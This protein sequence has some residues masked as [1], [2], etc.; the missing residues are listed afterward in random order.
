MRLRLP[1]GRTAFVVAALLFAL[2]A[3]LP[4]RLA[5][6]WFGFG[7]RGLTAR[8]V[9]GSVW[10]GALQQAQMGPVALGDVRARLNL[11]PLLLGRARLSLR[12]ADETAPI[13]GAVTVSRSGIAVD[14]VSGRLRIGGGM[15]LAT[16]DLQDL[17]AGFA[18]G[19]CVRA[20]GRVRATAAGPLTGNALAGNVRCDGAA[21]LFPLAGPSGAERLELRLFGDGRW[22]I[23]L[24]V[25]TAD[26]AVA[27]RLAAA[28]LRRSGSGY[29][30]RI[31]GEF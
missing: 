21:L 13:S 8:A 4:M 25:R 2:V 5:L 20:E 26:P 18:A 11:L 31:Q 30:T 1:I 6:D 10:A 14:D 9:T 16:L 28:G 27:A 22:R 29:A 7:G 17:S 3:T 12:G 24:A 15:P 23:D 19:R